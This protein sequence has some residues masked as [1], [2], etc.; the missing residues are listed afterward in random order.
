MN[1]C[2]HF[3]LAALATPLLFA[4]SVNPTP[5]EPLTDLTG[6]DTS[7]AYSPQSWNDGAGQPVS[8]L[9]DG[10]YNNRAS[11]SGDVPYDVVYTLETPK[12]VNACRITIH[13]SPDR[14]PKDWTFRG[15]NDFDGTNF[16]SATWTDIHSESNEVGWVNYEKR[17][18]VFANTNAY[19]TYSLHVTAN[20]NGNNVQWDELDLCYLETPVQVTGYPG[21]FGPIEYGTSNRV[22]GADVTF[23]TFSGNWESPSGTDSSRCTGYK[24]Y[25]FNKNSEW[26]LWLSGETN[27][28]TFAVPG[29]STKVEWQYE[30]TVKIAVAAVEHGSVTGAGWYAAGETCTLTPVPDEGYEF[31]AWTGD[32]GSI[33]YKQTT[34]M[35]TEALN[36]TP[37]F[38]LSSQR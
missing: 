33:G 6:K 38:V 1:R 13:T 10:K 4:A 28:V 5:F 12:A 21:E 22:V 24:V 3:A 27:T 16:D 7:R 20:V 19:S 11:R 2:L 25:Q 17:L 18:Y 23:S 15:S 9:F 35:V 30:A 34:F 26:E 32:H 31:V 37:M 29:N 8:V 14:V 36:L